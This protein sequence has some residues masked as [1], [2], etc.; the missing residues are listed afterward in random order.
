MFDAFLRVV[1]QA[2]AR[3]AFLSNSQLEALS[4]LAAESNKRMDVVNRITSNATAIVAKAA[5]SLF[6]EQ[7]QLITL[8]G[9]AYTARRMAAC[10]HDMDIILRYITYAM[11]AGDASVL[12]D[13]CLN[14]LA[15]TYVALG[16]PNVSVA[17]AIQKMK[18]IAIAIVMDPT[19]I[20]PG[21]C[22]SIIAELAGYFDLAAAS[23]V[24][25]YNYQNNNIELTKESS[26]PESSDEIRDHTTTSKQK[27]ESELN[28]E[29][30]I[31]LIGLIDEKDINAWIEE[32]DSEKDIDTLILEK[33]YTLK[34]KV[35]ASA[36]EV[37][38]KELAQQV[39]EGFFDSSKLKKGLDTEWVVSSST[40]RLAKAINTDTQ[41]CLTTTKIPNGN[42][43]A[44]KFSI[45]IPIYG[46][47]AVF[48]IQVIPTTTENASLSVL[49]YACGD[50]YCS[51]DIEF[52]VKCSELKP[53][54][55]LVF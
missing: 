34:L 10:L 45:F 15:E 18:E 11:F 3:G 19:G 23:V 49:I 14:G 6:A 20:T 2:D 53:E 44:A 27:T 31:N 7:P 39:P 29:I 4:L 47:S 28:K 40:V 36:Q 24:T 41:P 12:E 22:S 38:T 48:P 16:V 13:R 32:I 51:C 25:S 21:D 50:L 26:S 33:P 17:V 52:N 8:G 5:R 35:C 30:G 9:N 43:W 42:V 37:I 46:D 54:P 55:I 1:S